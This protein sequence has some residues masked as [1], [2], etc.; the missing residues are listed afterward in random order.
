MLLVSTV[1]FS[2]LFLS[3]FYYRQDFYRTWL[4]ASIW[5]ARRVS[6]KKKELLTLRKHL[7]SLPVFG[8]I[9]VD[10]LCSFRCCVVFFW[11]VCLRPV[12]CVP[13]VTSV[14]GFSILDCSFG[15]PQ[16]LVN[17]I[18]GRLRYGA[19]SFRI[20]LVHIDCNCWYSI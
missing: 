3:F 6:Y 16:H 11:F 8:A 2:V 12:S 17:I 19:F 5:V 7:G 18:H 20:S 15:F 14:S 1:Y 9:H 4:Y 13:N 10:Y